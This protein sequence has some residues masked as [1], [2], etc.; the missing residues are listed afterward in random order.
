MRE[1]RRSALTNKIKMIKMF[2]SLPRN[3]ISGAADFKPP[4]LWLRA[5]LFTKVPL[6]TG[7]NQH[8]ARFVL[9]V[10]SLW[11]DHSE[12]PDISPERNCYLWDEKSVQS[13][14]VC[15]VL[16][17]KKCVSH[18]FTTI[19][20]ARTLYTLYLKLA[21]CLNLNNS[22]PI[23]RQYVVNQSKPLNHAF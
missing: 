1:V 2:N 21:Y 19:Y 17:L 23:S 14:I 7:R 16:T 8:E 13:L 5:C 10:V 9:Q 6:L 20:N 22:D 4:S 15:E 3:T 18:R 12:Q 11:S